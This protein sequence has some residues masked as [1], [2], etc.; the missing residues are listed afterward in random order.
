M[1]IC[2]LTGCYEV[3]R[4]THLVTK[5]LGQCYSACGFP[6]FIGIA[7]VNGNDRVRISKLLFLAGKKRQS[8]HE[9]G[10]REI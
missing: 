8:C 7:T 2:F 6:E 5:D 9:T 1:W 10:T 3:E 4:D